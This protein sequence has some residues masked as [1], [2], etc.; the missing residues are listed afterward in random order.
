MDFPTPF[1]LPLTE[2]TFAMYFKGNTEERGG[3]G[4][5]QEFTLVCIISATCFNSGFP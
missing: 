2:I 1:P 3:G 4:G 5:P